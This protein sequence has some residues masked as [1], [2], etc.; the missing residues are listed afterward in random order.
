MSEK[1]ILVFILLHDTNDISVLPY[2]FNVVQL[3]Y[4]AYVCLLQFTCSFMKES[5]RFL[6]T[7]L[8]QEAEEETNTFKKDLGLF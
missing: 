6:Q 3:S 2:E 1:C 7:V 5:R 4:N 8:V